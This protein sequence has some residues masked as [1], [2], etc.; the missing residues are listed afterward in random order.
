MVNFQAETGI[1]AL[2]TDTVI[3]A[4]SVYAST[5][6][7]YWNVAWDSAKNHQVYGQDAS[8]EGIG[9]NLRLELAIQVN[10]DA[11]EALLAAPLAKLKSLVDHQC[12]FAS[13]SPLGASPSTLEN[14]T[15]WLVRVNLGEWNYLKIWE[16]ERLSCTIRPGAHAVQMTFKEQNLTLEISAPVDPLSG[17]AVERALVKKAIVQL[18]EINESDPVLWSEKLFRNLQNSIPGLCSLTVDL[19]RHESL[20]VHS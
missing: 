16:S 18:N 6:H 9:S 2:M 19:G 3:L 1:N 12:L 7:R 11:S 10:S 14:L 13:D 8:V 20:V 17:L 5:A 4:Q 15:L